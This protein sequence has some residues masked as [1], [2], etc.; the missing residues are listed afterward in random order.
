MKEKGWLEPII[1]Y[2]HLLYLTYIFH[3]HHCHSHTTHSAVRKHSE[4][5]SLSWLYYIVIERDDI[6]ESV[7]IS[8]SVYHYHLSPG[9]LR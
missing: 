7:C 5:A 3:H 8:E 1:Y 4:K 9:N 6:T 2:T